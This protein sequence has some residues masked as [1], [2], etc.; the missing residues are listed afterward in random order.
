[1]KTYAPI[2]IVTYSRISH[3]KECIE[4]LKQCPE[5]IYSD[6]FVALDFPKRPQDEA[7]NLDIQNYVAKLSGFKSINLIKREENY[8]GRRN[9]FDARSKILETYDTIITT[10]DDNVF[11]NKF[12]SYMNKALTLF[13]DR[14]EIFAITGYNDDVVIPN[15]YKENIYFRQG[16]CMWGVGFW[17]EKLESVDWDMRLF[18]ERLKNKNNLQKVKKFHLKAIPQL[19]RMRDNGNFQSDGFLFLYLISTGK[20]CVY[21]SL[22]LVRNIGHDGSG[23]HCGVNE[24]YQ[25]QKIN[26]EINSLEFNENSTQFNIELQKSISKQLDGSLSKRIRVLSLLYPSWVKNITYFFLDNSQLF[27]RKLI[28]S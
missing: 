26:E 4:S 16:C 15:W 19:L 23:L 13:K 1:M 18:N 3:L 20:F 14:E 17:K 27:Y 12:L 7:G 8:G 11:S 10:E 25:N 21:P 22:S 5:A 2:L 24:K 6:L 9:Y 28:K